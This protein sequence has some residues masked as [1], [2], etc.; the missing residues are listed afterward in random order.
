MLFDIY[1]GARSVHLKIELTHL[2]IS[3]SPSFLCAYMTYNL[4]YFICLHR[5]I[6]KKGRTLGQQLPVVYFAGVPGPTLGQLALRLSGCFV[7]R[8]DS[9]RT[10]MGFQILHL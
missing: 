2:N 10:C 1:R 5:G 3:L 4:I 6:C 7:N 8:R 9:L